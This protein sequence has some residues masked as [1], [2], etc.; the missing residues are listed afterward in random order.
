MS[1]PKCARVEPSRDLLAE[2]SSEVAQR[3]AAAA[4][5][6]KRRREEKRRQELERATKRAADSRAKATAAVQAATRAPES[7]F[8]R[9]EIGRAEGLLS[10]AEGR[11]GKARSARDW[12]QVKTRFDEAGTAASEALVTARARAEAERLRQEQEEADR[13]TAVASSTEGRHL[14]EDVASLPHERLL[15]GVLAEA[16]ARLLDVEQA[17]DQ[18]DWSR[19]AQLGPSALRKA[20]S[21]AKK[22]RAAHQE[23]EARRA[24]IHS[25]LEVVEQ[26]LDAVDWSWM[27]SLGIDGEDLRHSLAQARAAA[28]NDDLDGAQSIG[29]TIEPSLEERRREAEEVARSVAERDRIVREVAGAIADMGYKVTEARLEDPGLQT[30]VARIR[31]A[32]AGGAE[33]TFSMGLDEED[34]DFN[35]GDGNCSDRVRRLIEATRERGLNFEV[36]SW[37]PGKPPQ[38]Q[39]EARQLPGAREQ[40]I[41]GS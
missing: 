25:A 21:V 35:I 8:A 3:L 28:E 19:A 30:S 20:R 37:G 12:R 6:E 36:S 18:G 33:F 27:G 32:D 15:P 2:I 11:Q 40:E 23:F 22:I 7:S 9:D 5:A 38:R 14:L 10:E 41:E 29:D 24:E 26:S 1:G 34:A 16:R 31:A 13:A 17:G 4:A 39:G